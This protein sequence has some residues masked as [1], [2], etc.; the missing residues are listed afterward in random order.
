MSL[1]V[2]ARIILRGMLILHSGMLN[3]ITFVN[4]TVLT[5]F[6]ALYWARKSGTVA[7]DPRVYGRYS[8]LLVLQRG[9]VIEVVINN[10]DPGDHPFHL[11]GH[12]FQVLFRSS[13]GGGD[14]VYNAT[15]TESSFTI[16][17]M[18]RDVINV[19]S[20]GSVLLRF[21]A[22]NP[23]IWMFHCHLEWQVHDQA[24]AMLI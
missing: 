12:N 21:E 3:D 9:E 16:N 17:P 15:I 24:R 8:N 11:H 6:S 2:C 14:F 23:G 13:R 18:R 7:N 10:H 22:D 4:Q 5:L 20:K 19:P 1:V